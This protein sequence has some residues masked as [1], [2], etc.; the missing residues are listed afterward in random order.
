MTQ[1]RPPHPRTPFIVRGI[2]VT[3]VFAHLARGLATTAFVFPFAG[4]GSRNRMVQRWSQG[5][6]RILAVQLEHTSSGAIPE[7]TLIVAN[8]ISWLDIFVL[9][10][11]Q[12]SRFIAKSDIKRWPLV[13]F[14]VGGVGT[15][16]LDRTRRR[17]AGRINAAVAGALDAG[18]VIALFPEGTTTEGRELLPF[19]GSLL[20]PVIE[21]R[22]H[23][24]PVAIRYT[25]IDGSHSIAPA[26][27]GDTSLV[28]SFRQLLRAPRTRVQL[29]LCAP[30]PAHGRRRR[31]IAAEAHRIIRT[32][33]EL[34]EAETRH[35]PAGQTGMPPL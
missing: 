12:P 28:T 22:G 29:H 3:R 1:A 17:D 32:A 16:F 9:N 33:L 23:V 31:E 7:R 13:G 2:R 4:H 8:H 25:H 35:G 14:L 27:V 20:Q 10:A 21:A 18:D 5:L 11:L 34:P 30:L 6:L 15:L 24:L 26:Y 19:H